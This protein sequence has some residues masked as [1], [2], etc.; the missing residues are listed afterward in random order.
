MDNYYNAKKAAQDLAMSLGTLGFDIQE[1]CKQM[2]IEHRS[3]QAAFTHLCLQWLKT[4]AELKEN[5]AFDERNNLEVYMG[6]YLA[7]M[8]RYYLREAENPTVKTIYGNM[9]AIPFEDRNAGDDSFMGAGWDIEFNGQAVAAIEVRP[10]GE[11]LVFLYKEGEENEGQVQE[12]YN[13]HEG[14]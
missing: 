8:M 3:N 4:C 10:E 9:T 14:K 5:N 13:W 2:R 6:N 1:F 11:V 7:K 12:F